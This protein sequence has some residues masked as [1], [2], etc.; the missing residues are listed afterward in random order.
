MV[1]YLQWYSSTIESSMLIPEK[2]T[3]AVT[4]TN[5]K[6]LITNLKSL[7]IERHFYLLYVQLTRTRKKE[8]EGREFHLIE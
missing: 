7:Y 2:K 1:V 6:N 4:K 3:N 5:A 8:A